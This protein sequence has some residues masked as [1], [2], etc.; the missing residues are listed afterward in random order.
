MF[1][2]NKLWFLNT[3]IHLCI[4]RCPKHN[5]SLYIVCI[6]LLYSMCKKMWQDIDLNSNATKWRVFSSTNYYFGWPVLL[7]H[8]LV[9]TFILSNLT[10]SFREKHVTWW[11]LVLVPNIV[12]LGYVVTEFYCTLKDIFYKPYTSYSMYWNISLL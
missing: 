8:I 2:K 11:W 6:N 5:I 7:Y 12:T 1:F 4:Q 3:F 9:K 10:A